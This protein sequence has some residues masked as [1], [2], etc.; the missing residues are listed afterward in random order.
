PPHGT[1]P[2]ANPL[3]GDG[4]RTVL[5]THPA[6]RIEMSVAPP[7]DSVSETGDKV[8]SGAKQSTGEIRQPRGSP[9]LKRRQRDRDPLA[10]EEGKEIAG[11]QGRGKH[12]ERGGKSAAVFSHDGF[13]F[14]LELPQ[15]AHRDQGLDRYLLRT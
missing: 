9:G 14:V 6:I 5:D 3:F 12:H 11:N 2:L 13:H 1:K 8:R 15:G 7:A 10:L 4:V